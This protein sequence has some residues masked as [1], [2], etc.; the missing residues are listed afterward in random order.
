LSPALNINLLQNSASQGNPDL[1]PTHSHNIDLSIEDYLPGAG[2]VSLGFF[3]K[4]LQDYIIPTSTTRSYPNNGIFAGLTGRVP[5]A[6]FTNGPGA[7]ALGYEFALQRKFIELPGLWNGFGAGFNWTG[8][9]SHIQIHPNANSTLPSTAKNTGNATLF[10][11]KEGLLD[12]R[13]G[14]NYISR[15]LFAIFATP[16][17]DVYSEPRFSLDLGSRYFVSNN[18][19]LYFDVKNITNTPLKYTEGDSHRPLQR[20][21]YRE[22]YQFGVT[23]SF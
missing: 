23:A 6:T 19:S 7:R 4:D 11:E 21:F 18:F 13:L 17:T 5:V 22:T 16:A 8:V 15:S 3:Y 12:V 2:I 14:A 1:K 9:S 20:E 10:Y